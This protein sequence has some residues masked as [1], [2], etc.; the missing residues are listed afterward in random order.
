[1]SYIITFSDQAS[2]S[3]NSK[4][5]IT[6][7]VGSVDNSSTSLF[8]TGKGTANYGLLQQENLLHLLEHFASTAA[9]ANPTVGQAWYDTANHQLKVCVSVSPETWRLV[10]AYQIT[11]VG[12]AAP[13]PAALGDLWFQRT[14]DAS[15]FLYVYTGLGRF[16]LSA[17]AMGGWDQLWP[18]VQVAGG[19]DEYDELRLLIEQLIGSS[20]SYGSGAIGRSITNL[21]NF[22]V[23]DADLRAKYKALVG[24]DLITDVLATS[25]SDSG[26]TNQAPSYSLFF[27]PDVYSNTLNAVDFTVSGSLTTTTAG[28]IYIDG[29]STSVPAGSVFSS[30]YVEDAYVMYISDAAQ[31]LLSGKAYYVVQQNGNVWQYDNNSTWFPFTPSAQMFIIGTFSNTGVESVEGA[32]AFPGDKV[33]QA[34]MHAVRMVGAKYEH[35]VVQPIS[36]DWDALLAAGRYALNRLELPA[37]FYKQVSGIPFV[38]DG[39]QAPADLTALSATDVR[40]PTAAR[41][42]SKRPGTISQYQQYVAT[43]NAL[44]SAI[45]NKFSLKG[46][47]GSSGTNGDFSGAGT[48]SVPATPLVTTSGT[49]T[50]SS[51]TVS[52]RVSFA[53]RDQMIRWFAAGQGLQVT[54]S[55]TG[56][57]TGD[58]NLNALFSSYGLLRVTG[59]AVRIFGSSSPYTMTQSK[60]E[61][62]IWNLKTSSTTIGTIT[63]G[64]SSIQLSGDRASTGT[65]FDLTLVI[66]P[67][68]TCTG[69]TTVSVNAIDD[70]EVTSTSSRVYPSISAAVWNLSF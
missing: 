26:I 63:N 43:Q 1:M 10:G 60:I 14:G 31:Y 53:D 5:P 6:V 46:I 33:C 40:Y 39:R 66:T 52:V 41:R 8:L 13:T 3:D 68:G 65:Y 56:S 20:C 30:Q 17:S 59:D 27:L 64:T 67:N 35:L 12:E 69:T 2:V 21:T 51:K 7:A 38:Y 37:G 25:S 22:G 16:P 48:V 55:Q 47:N 23:L 19:R 42:G 11:D 34:W 45:E 57:G 54:L 49:I 24:A 44:L 9:P 28:S 29:V 36:Q 4:D 15:G 61:V 18:Q 70:A 32:V 58:V 62:G 50:G